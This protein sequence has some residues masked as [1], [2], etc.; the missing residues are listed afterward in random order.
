[1]IYILK[2]LSLCYVNIVSKMARIGKVKCTCYHLFVSYRRVVDFVIVMQFVRFYDHGDLL[3]T[4]Q[5]DKLKIII[6]K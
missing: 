1:L 2:S 3:R 5:N 6:D 4:F